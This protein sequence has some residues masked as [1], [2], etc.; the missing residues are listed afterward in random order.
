MFKLSKHIV[1]AI[2]L[3]VASTQAQLPQGFVYVDEIDA[4]IQQSIRYCSSE[5]FVGRVLD[6]YK[7]PR[8][9][10]SQQAA[11]ALAAAQAA[12]KEDGYSIV[13]YDTDLHITW[14][15]EDPAWVNEIESALETK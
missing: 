8:A 14:P 9:I 5:N 10:L 12:F 2:A 13:I 15:K 1:I 6:G 4:S 3:C 7:K 11:T